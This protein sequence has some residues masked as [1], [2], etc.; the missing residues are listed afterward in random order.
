MH[1]FL[2]IEGWVE[3]VVRGSP[4]DTAPGAIVVVVERFC[5]DR[6]AHGRVELGCQA[7][8]SEILGS[9]SKKFYN[10][11][12]GG[13]VHDRNLRDRRSRGGPCFVRIDK[14]YAPNRHSRPGADR[15]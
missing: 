12:P 15:T 2:K 14:R 7:D 9:L 3:P 1:Q 6:R 5:K 4:G 13:V 11:L 8:F 10:L